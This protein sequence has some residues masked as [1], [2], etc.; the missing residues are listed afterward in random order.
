MSHMESP[1]AHFPPSEVRND[2]YQEYMLDFISHILLIASS[3]G[4]N[5]TQSGGPI[6][7]LQCALIPT[8]KLPIVQ[9]VNA[10]HNHMD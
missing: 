9:C 1:G 5:M 4:R 8:H 10:L 7:L 6:M 2:G 3:I